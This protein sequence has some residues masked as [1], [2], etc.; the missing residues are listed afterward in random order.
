VVDKLTDDV[1]DRIDDAL[2]NYPD[3]TAVN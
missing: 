3:D 2:A 1:L